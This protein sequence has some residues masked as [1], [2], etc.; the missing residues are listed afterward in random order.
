MYRRR[1]IPVGRARYSTIRA[2]YPDFHY[3]CSESECGNGSM[4]WKA[5][6]HTFF[7]ISDNMGN[8]CD[9][10]YNWNFLLPDNGESPWG[11]KQ[12]ALI[13]VDSKTRSI[14][15]TPEYYAVKHFSNLIP[16]GSRMVGYSPRSEGNN[17]MATAFV[18]PDG[19]TVIV[20][21]NFE[22]TPRDISLKVKGKYLNNTLAPHSF[23]TFTL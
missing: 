18:T 4:D 8:G 22:D 10:W 12:N 13:Q 2:R 1:G 19:K 3:I 5:G 9:E 11:W 17:V 16:A 7:L 23:N 21:G 15:Y 20:T 14:R 6:E